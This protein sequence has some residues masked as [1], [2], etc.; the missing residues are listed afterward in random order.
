MSATGRSDVRHPDDFYAT[1]TWCTRLILPHLPLSG[2]V[3]EPCAGTGAI[4]RELIAHGVT[5]D[6]ITAVE[7]DPERASGVAAICADY[8]AWAPAERVDC[9]VTNPP[10]KLAMEFVQRSLEHASVS[11]MLLRQGFLASQRRHAWLSKHVPDVYQ[12]ARRPSFTGGGTDA[13]DYVWAVWPT[14]MVR[15]SGAFRYLELEAA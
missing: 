7:R 13:A 15:T 8:L 9:V 14:S 12:L 10:Y 5:R 3:L 2:T 6:R 1:P 4:V 11:A